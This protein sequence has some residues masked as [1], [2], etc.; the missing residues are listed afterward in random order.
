[1]QLLMSILRKTEVNVEYCVSYLLVCLLV[2]FRAEPGGM[3]LHITILLRGLV[4]EVSADSGLQ[5]DL[6]I[7]LSVVSAKVQPHELF[8]S[9]ENALKIDLRNRRRF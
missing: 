5:L 1:M 8:S 2:Q 3:F 9:A 6:E 4:D 7:A